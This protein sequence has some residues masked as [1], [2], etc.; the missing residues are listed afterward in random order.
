MHKTEKHS[1]SIELL[2]H[3]LEQQLCTRV[4]R[5]TLCSVGPPVCNTSSIKSS[6]F[7]FFNEAAP[8][9]F[10]PLPPHAPLPIYRACATPYIRGKAGVDDCP[11]RFAAG[12]NRQL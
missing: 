9:E 8:P 5:A 10:S 1:I 6:I 4:R 3:A 2:K 11:G 7:F 12:D